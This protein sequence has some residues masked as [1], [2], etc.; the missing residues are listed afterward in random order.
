MRKTTSTFV[1]AISVMLLLMLGCQPKQADL[2][3]EQKAA[4]ADT[5]T[6]MMNQ[7]ITSAEAVNAEETGALLMMDSTSIFFINGI[8]YSHCELIAS[9]D[10]LY[11]ELAW[12][13]INFDFTQVFVLGPDAAL[14]VGYGTN[15]LPKADG[16]EILDITDTW[17][18]QKKRGKW[19]VYHL[20][21]SAIPASEPAAE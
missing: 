10:S 2:T 17:L 3:L 15:V 11:H 21:E 1:S 20:H 9:L 7:L 19:G 5:I 6:T 12:Q 4:I 16:E 18:W 13:K 8:P 14:W